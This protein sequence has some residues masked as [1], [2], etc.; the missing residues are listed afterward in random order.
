MEMPLWF[1]LFINHLNCLYIYIDINVQDGYFPSKGRRGIFP[2]RSLDRKKNS[3]TM[4]S[5]V[6]PFIIFSN[7]KR[8]RKRT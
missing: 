7:E 2:S 4:L 1:I 5:R 6:F 8:K 3:K